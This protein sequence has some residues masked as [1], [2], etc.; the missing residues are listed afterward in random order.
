MTHLH[1]RLLSKLSKKVSHNKLIN[2]FDI[3]TFQIQKD[4]YLENKFVLGGCYLSD[5]K[6][7]CFKDRKE[8]ANYLISRKF[9]NQ[10]WFATNLNFDF[11]STFKNIKEDFKVIKVHGKLI[12]AKY[13]P[14]KIEFV[15]TF[16]F[17]KQSV[18][19]LGKILSEKEG[20]DHLT[21]LEFPFKNSYG[22]AEYRKP[23]TDKEWG[24]L[25]VYNLK[26]AEISQKFG[27]FLQHFF[28]SMGCKMKITIAST[29]LDFWRRR[30]QPKVLI[31]TED[32]RIMDLQYAS[33]RGG[34]TMVYQRG[35]F[36]EPMTL[37]DV[38][39]MYPA[40]CAEGCDG[41]GAYPDPN[42]VKYKEQGIIE[43]IKYLEGVARVVMKCPEDEYDP[44]LY[45]GERTDKLIFPRGIVKG[46]YTFPEIRE[47]LKLGY[48]I[49]EIKE[50]IVYDKF[51]PFKECAEYLYKSRVKQK[52][53]GNNAI[54]LMLKIMMNSGLYG[55]FGQN[56]K[57]REECYLEKDFFV[58][59]HGNPF[60]KTDRGIKEIDN[61]L[62]RG[63]F[64]YTKMKNESDIIKNFMFPIFASYT[65]A[66]A[67]IKL[68]RL[69]RQY[70]DNILY[71][72]TDS[73]LVKGKVDL[74]SEKLGDLSKEADIVEA[75]IIKPKFYMYITKEK[76]ERMKCKGVRQM[77]K[78]EDFIKLLQEG[79]ITQTRFSGYKE[80][81]VRN[82]PFASIIPITKYIGM[83][84]NKRVWK[85]LFRFDTNQNSEAILNT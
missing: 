84:D 48:E 77:K 21:K 45:D 7:I 25:A 23:R 74:Y 26:D 32:K 62:I 17:V 73:L 24:E 6:K 4:W 81:H 66:L 38:R 12:Y 44:L 76:L 15:D 28:N 71:T 19:S 72:D 9:K 51:Y 39:S 59:K 10:V 11:L 83:E 75:I 79:K 2:G 68:H 69:V 18:A 82:I 65:T 58:D 55:K 30:Y 42:T 37:L 50:S 49:L 34:K 1:K 53:L 3:E 33:Y 29:G 16:N 80:S 85:G 46:C 78:H 27:V 14:Y 61:Y 67:R 52:K 70:G 36:K 64:I 22:E 41:K 56:N 40:I 57:N 31:Q 5:G 20:N 13:K 35:Y 47:A 54:Q 63:D 60:V 8:Y 43:D